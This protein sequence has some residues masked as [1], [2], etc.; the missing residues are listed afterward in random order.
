MRKKLT[1]NSKRILALTLAFVLTFGV[2]ISGTSLVA[3][4]EVPLLTKEM[5]LENVL[6]DNLTIIGLEEQLIQLND[7]LDNISGYTSALTSVQ[8]LVAD[9]NRLGEKVIYTKAN[10][11]RLLQLL[12]NMVIGSPVVPPQVHPD[13]AEYETILAGLSPEEFGK[14][15]TNPGEYAQ[16]NGYGSAMSL[17]GIN[18]LT[19]SPDQEYETFILPSYLGTRSLQ[20]GIESL[21]EGIVSAKGGISVGGKQLYNTVLM[22]TDLLDILDLSYETSVTNYN[23]AKEKN[24]K[25]LISD[26]SLQINYNNMVTAELNKNKMIRDID[27]LKMSM[28]VMMGRSPSEQFNVESTGTTIVELRS[29]ESYINEA[30][31]QRSEI[32][33]LNRSVE[34]QEFKR[35]FVK[36]IYS[37]SDNRYVIEE[38]QLELYKVQLEEAVND[39][40]VE[41]Y[42]AFNDVH[43][44]EAALEIANLELADAY[45]QYQELAINVEQGFVTE[46]M[47]MNINLLVTS[48]VNNAS[49][50]SRD[51][52]NAVESLSD[53]SSFGP[54]SST[55]G[56]TDNE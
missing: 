12:F 1:T 34:D 2:Y 30:I 55:I 28:N 14:L 22:L 33:S 25:G 36:D 24:Q 26:I 8:S 13:Q 38:K 52:L 19:V 48:A 3:E 42:K 32:I 9:Y 21:E 31:V 51:Y 5:F 35:I 39:I 54:G 15:M 50:A 49:T 29:V 43:E 40:T 7:Q 11:P 6:T 53:G 45:R 47:L 23:H 46:S 10:Q 27:N 18:T 17:F 44:K 41:V 37:Q 20:S 56:G 16:Y 4:E